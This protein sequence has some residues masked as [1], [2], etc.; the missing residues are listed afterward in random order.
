MK[1]KLVTPTLNNANMAE[2]ILTNLTTHVEVF[3]AQNNQVN[4][5]SIKLPEFWSKSPEVWFASVESQ[6]GVKGITQNHQKYDY[7]VSALGINTAE[8][9]QSVLINPPAESKYNT[10]KKALN[11]TFCKSQAQKD[12]ELL[13]LNG[14]GKNSQ[15]LSYARSTPSMT[16][17]RHSNVRCS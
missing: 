13:N 9:V 8:E 16:I 6:F 2:D 1:T 17:L 11:K 15:L 7:I 14:L 4:T 12:A 10:L 5:V 3:S